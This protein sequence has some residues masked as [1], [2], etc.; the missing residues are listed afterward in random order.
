MKALTR[1]DI[2]PIRMSV[3]PDETIVN[4]GNKII[5]KGKI[6]HYVGIGWVEEGKAEKKDYQ[7]IP[8]VL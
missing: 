3:N 1:N 5:L 6:Y 4:A 7:N 2:H 8:E